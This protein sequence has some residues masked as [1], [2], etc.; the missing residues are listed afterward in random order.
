MRRPISAWL[1]DMDGVLVH[2]EEP[3]PG[4]T[5]FIEALKVSGLRF[6]VLTNNSIFTARDLRAR[7]LASGINVPEEAIW[8][9]ALATRSPAPAKKRAGKASSTADQGVKIPPEPRL[10]LTPQPLN[11]IVNSIGMRL[12]LIPAGEFLMGRTE[13]TKD[14]VGHLV[15][16]S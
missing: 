3:I 4:A 13:A 9:S 5:D 2:E 16:I 15:I 11:E 14:A 1:T 12:K 8:T 10:L 6:L 7:L